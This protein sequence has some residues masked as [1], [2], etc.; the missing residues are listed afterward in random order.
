MND[1]R[2]KLTYHAVYDESIISALKYAQKLGFAGIQ[3][4]VETPHFSFEE[5]SPK[6]IA[7][8]G[9]FREQ[10]DLLLSI[11]APDSLTSMFTSSPTL[12]AGIFDYLE[13]LLSFAQTV[14]AHI[15]T[16]HPGA[17]VVYR[18]DEASPR[19]FPYVDEKIYRAL[20]RDNLKRL[21]ELNEGK[22]TICFESY[23]TSPILFTELEEHLQKGNFYLCWD[24]AKTWGKSE[25][26]DYLWQHLDMVK[27]VHLHDV[28]EG[29]SHLIVGQGEIDFQ[30]YLR[31]FKGSNIAEVCFEVRPKEAALKSKKELF[32]LLKE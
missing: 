11:H 24:V 7:E 5:L 23:Q 15:V 6:E 8:I 32:K 1:I 19:T 12:L 4:A 27:Q 30:P 29:R 31:A 9:S 20:F 16:L 21:T 22:T 10:N 14:G 18:T 3:L 26:E 13:K 28:R 2:A 25:V 17:P